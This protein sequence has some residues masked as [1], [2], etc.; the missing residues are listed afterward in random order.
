MFVRV[1]H[2]TTESG[3]WDRFVSRLEHEGLAA[4]RATDGFVRMVVT[5]DPMSDTVVT[6]TFWET[7]AKERGYEVAKAH[8]FAVLV[9]ALV[10]GAPETFAYPVV[11]DSAA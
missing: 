8:D 4:M 3:Q 1:R 11:S 9:K 2:W 5:G 6:L 10:T 7:E